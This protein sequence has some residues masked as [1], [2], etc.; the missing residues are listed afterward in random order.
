MLLESKAIGPAP[1]NSPNLVLDIHI[2]LKDPLNHSIKTRY[3]IKRNP[4]CA[5][6]IIRELA[7][8]W[9][10]LIPSLKSRWKVS[11]YLMLLFLV[12]LFAT[13]AVLWYFGHF[14]FD[15][16]L[17]IASIATAVIL[18][19]FIVSAWIWMRG[20]TNTFKKRFVHKILQAY[21]VEL[22]H[23]YQQFNFTILHP[24]IFYFQS[25]QKSDNLEKIEYCVVR[26]SEGIVYCDTK[27]EPITFTTSD[28][29]RE[30]HSKYERSN[31]HSE[32]EDMASYTPRSDTNP[33][34]LHQMRKDNRKQYATLSPLVHHSPFITKFNFNNHNQNSLNSKIQNVG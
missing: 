33:P 15:R 20:A 1:C 32:P 27:G 9:N 2:C 3:G 19:G 5:D 7:T 24:V 10:S 18:T 34:I 16:F 26:I 25:S 6:V 13:P 31:E 12:L 11:K 28:L 22:A 8:H 4:F 29:M 30:I 21:V 23:R 14:S 17:L